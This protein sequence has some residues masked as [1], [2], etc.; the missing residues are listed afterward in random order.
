MFRK[1]NS[2]WTGRL[3]TSPLPAGIG[4][5][6]EITELPWIVAAPAV[7]RA[8]NAYQRRPLACRGIL[9]QVECGSERF[10]EYDCSDATKK[11]FEKGLRI[12]DVPGNHHTMFENPNLQVLAQ[13]LGECLEELSRTGLPCAVPPSLKDGAPASSVR[14]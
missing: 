4:N 6:D 13:R 8:L 2:K 1:L 3:Q 14:E 9:F 11:L 7:Y 5:L 10:P 12:V